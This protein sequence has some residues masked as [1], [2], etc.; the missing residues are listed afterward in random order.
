MEDW[1]QYRFFLEV[2]RMGS[3]SG[4]ARELGVSQPTVSRRIAQLERRLDAVLFTQT[5][6]G[7]LL[8]DAGRRMLQSAEDIAAAATELKHKVDLH[9]REPAGTV[10]LSAPGALMDG[11][12]PEQLRAFRSD[13]PDILVECMA[14]DRPPDLAKGECDVAVI[15]G[16]PPPSFAIG[17]RIT[18]VTFGV[19]GAQSYLEENGT[20]KSLADL[21]SHHFIAATGHLA[22][23]PQIDKFHVLMKAGTPSFRTNCSQTYVKFA[24]E[25]NG[26]VC[27][28]DLCAARAPELTRVVPEKFGSRAELWLLSHPALKKSVRV[29]ALLD[30]IKACAVGHTKAVSVL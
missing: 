9:E 4:A 6:G 15:Y 7:V 20:P 23:I 5:Q 13:Y 16:R 28:S 17:S 18:N 26:L 30:H 21:S 3:L 11:W 19:Y 1:D 27:I 29:R 10:S 12:L 2:A 24:R 8:T 25:G 14:K 22:C